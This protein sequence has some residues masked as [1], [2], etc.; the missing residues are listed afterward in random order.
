MFRTASN[1]TLEVSIFDADPLVVL[2]D[3]TWTP[4]GH[5]ETFN[6]SHASATF[7]DIYPW[8][9]SEVMVAVSHPAG[10]RSYAFR[11]TILGQLWGAINFAMHA[12]YVNLLHTPFYTYF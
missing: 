2:S 8:N 4:D 6:G 9:T 11:L 7:R 1:V 12:T 5:A 10:N 3:I